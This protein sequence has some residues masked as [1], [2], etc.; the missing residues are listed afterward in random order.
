ML[1]PRGGDERQYLGGILLCEGYAEYAERIWFLDLYPKEERDSLTQTALEPGSVH[2]R[3]M[4]WIERL[5]KNHGAKILWEIPKRWR[6][7]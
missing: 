6:N 5:V 7:Y 4:R 1:R 2:D 3:G